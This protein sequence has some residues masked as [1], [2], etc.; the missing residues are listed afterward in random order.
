MVIGC[1]ITGKTFTFFI[2]AYTLK[3]S[4]LMVS[5]YKHVAVF[6]LVVCVFFQWHLG[7]ETSPSLSICSWQ[8]D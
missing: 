2:A 4:A 1:S 5:S 3:H 7:C 6:E 8:P